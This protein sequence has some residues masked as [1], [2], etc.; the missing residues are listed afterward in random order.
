MLF[1]DQIKRTH[2]CGDLR[3]SHI[4]SSVVL[5][6]WVHRNRD[7]G[8]QLFVTLRDISGI[9]QLRFDQDS[10]ALF[11]EARHLR[12]EWVI[13]ITGTVKSRG[14]N[15]N[16]D[17][18]TGE[19]EVVVSR[20]ELMSR[21]DPIPFM[22]EDK[23]DATEETRLS[24]R[25][26]DLR[27]P[28]MQNRMQ[29][30]SKANQITRNYLSKNGFIEIE[31]PILY[32]STP[33]GARD[34]LVPSRVKPGS[35]YALPQSPQTLKQLLMVA[36]Y[37]RYFQI[38][39]C[40]RDED[41]RADRQPEFTQIDM[42]MSFVNEDDIM[43]LVE[44]LMVDLMDG[45]IGLRIK[46]PFPRLSYE[47]AMDLYGCDRPDLRYPMPLH[48][49]TKIFKDSKFKVFEDALAADG[50]IKG[51]L[52]PGKAGMSRKELDSLNPIVARHGARGA[53]WFKKD[54]ETF[55][56]PAVKFL[57]EA[58]L[59][60]LD[61]EFSPVSGDL[62]LAL[63]G[64]KNVVNLGLGELRTTMG[65]QVFPENMDQFR[66][67]WVERF[68]L[69][70]KD[71]ERLT[72]VHHPFTQPAP[73]DMEFFETEP[74][75]VNA[76]A[77]DV[78]LNGTELGGGSIRIHDQEMQKK[79]FKFLGIDDIQAREK[80]GFLLDGL[81]YGAPPHGGLA[82]GMDRLI[83][84]LTGTTSIRDVIAFPKTTS[85]SCMMSG[86][87]SGVDLGQLKELGLSITALDKKSD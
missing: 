20:L 58:E 29:A 2:K 44:G 47:K 75:K 16:K 9:V 23:T 76:R 65:P 43:D 64:P 71:G 69:F 77:Y 74:L 79:I 82:I 3:A 13:G 32:K 81:R 50:I 38:A 30:R 46:R 41:L 18:P 39:R 55:K 62:I 85:A 36:G 1:V 78:I 80:F 14:D 72:S 73:E 56:G 12:Q 83:M 24:H 34:Y 40:F 11:E 49:L 22:I 15:V 42:E 31:T 26:L 17:M 5:M 54:G 27:R 70:E 52:V 7:F 37:D 57:S 6:G 19:V 4:D 28:V 84:L 63:A 59:A 86:A 35:F 53:L 68:P 87:P 61:A 66:F 51:I 45:I 25:F 67:L 33:E 10:E 21:A 48:N 8:G 60:I